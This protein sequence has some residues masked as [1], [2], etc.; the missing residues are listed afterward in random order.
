M[1]D[2]RYYS[3]TVE[4]GQFVE[5]KF[6]FSVATGGVLTPLNAAGA[7]YTTAGAIGTQSTID[8]FLGTT[9]EFNYLAF[10]ATSLGTDAEGFIINMGGQVDKLVGVRIISN[11]GTAGVTVVE[12]FVAASA[13]LTNTTLSTQWAKGA[14]GN[15]A[16]RYVGSGFDSLNGTLLEVTLYWYAK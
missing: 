1:K 6:L 4:S 9:S 11:A 7:C 8:T 5:T 14:D 2:I 13:S 16:G 15:V 3:D 10:D 12:N